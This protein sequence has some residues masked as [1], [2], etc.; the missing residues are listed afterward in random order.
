MSST[1]KR[2]DG[3]RAQCRRWAAKHCSTVP[4][5]GDLVARCN[6]ESG[7][8]PPPLWDAWMADAP[9][10]QSI[11]VHPDSHVTVRREGGIDCLFNACITTASG[12][13]FIIRK[14]NA[15]TAVANH[16]LLTMPPA[17]WRSG[18]AKGTMLRCAALYAELGLSRLTVLP[19]HLGRYIWT[20]CGA[21]PDESTTEAIHDAIEDLGDA[22]GRPE[23]AGFRPEFLWEYE[24][25]SVDSDGN[26]NPV[27]RDEILG[28]VD[29]EL[30]D[31]IAVPPAAELP[32][33]H[34]LLIYNR[35]TIWDASLSLQPGS[36]G[37]ERLAAYTG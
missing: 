28:A 30:L 20:M 33:G 4:A 37:L 5:S 16:A 8:L 17:T 13:G 31:E 25:L 23:V 36:P 34:A 15:E 9:A 14:L 2:P 21:H 12:Q 1:R 10:F 32:L 6:R 35:E 11:W 26:R 19:A 27:T 29:P 3:A 24:E 22:L 18:Y 7:F